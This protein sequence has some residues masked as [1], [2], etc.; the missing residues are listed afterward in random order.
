MALVIVIK[1]VNMI[2]NGEEGCD[3]GFT[4]GEGGVGE[5]GGSIDGEGCSKR[6]KSGYGGS[7]GGDGEDGGSGGK[8]FKCIMLV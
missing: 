2:N 4:R 3:G 5:N 7:I 1:T 8:K 6:G